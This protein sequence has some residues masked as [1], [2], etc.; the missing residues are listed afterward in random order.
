MIASVLRQPIGSVNFK[1]DASNWLS[2]D[3]CD[4]LASNVEPAFWIVYNS[5]V[6]L[7]TASTANSILFL[8]NIR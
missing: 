4:R 2:Q 3:A 6:P 5:Y 7:F 1:I 8:F